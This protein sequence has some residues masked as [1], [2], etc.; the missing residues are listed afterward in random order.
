MALCLL[1]GLV[2]TD[3]ET[4]FEITL[5]FMNLL[6]I[7]IH[8]TTLNCQKEKLDLLAKPRRTPW[9]IIEV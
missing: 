9:R 4:T 2:S 1:T 5:H 6:D 3:V 8:G 7:N